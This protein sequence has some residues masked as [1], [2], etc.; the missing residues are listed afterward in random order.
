M[1]WAIAHSQDPE[2]NT[3]YFVQITIWVEFTKENALLKLISLS[4]STVKITYVAHIIFIST[5]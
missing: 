2:L 5:G 4:L 1:G 3:Q